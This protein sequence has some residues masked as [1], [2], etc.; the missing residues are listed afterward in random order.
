[1]GSK[2]PKENMIPL[3]R[4]GNEEHDASVRAKLKGTSSKQRKIAQQI[5]RAREQVERGDKD[6]DELTLLISN[7]DASALNIVEMLKIAGNMNLK[8]QEYISLIRTTIEAHKTL[9][10]VKTFN[11]NINYGVQIE[12]MIDNWKKR[13]QEK[14]KEIKLKIDKPQKEI[15][16]KKEI[17]EE[18][19]VEYL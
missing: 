2:I 6:I 5:R 8:P 7:P 17:E 1:M 9:F 18:E 12:T 11:E 10:G 16:L 13:K 4:E 19:D 3:G 15:I 14:E